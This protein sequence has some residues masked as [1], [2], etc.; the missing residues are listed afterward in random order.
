MNHNLTIVR[1]ERIV[2]RTNNSFVFSTFRSNRDSQILSS[3]AF[4]LST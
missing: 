2:S 1:L 3:I 4:V